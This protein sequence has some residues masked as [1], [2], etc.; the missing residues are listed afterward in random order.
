MRWKGAVLALVALACLATGPGPWGGR[1]AAKAPEEVTFLH[2]WTGALRGGIDAMLAEVARLE[3]SVHVRL[4]DFE[5]ETFKVGIK[6]MLTSGRPPDLFSYWAGART[7]ALA[8]RGQLANLDEI[9]KTHAL[10]RRFPPAVVEAC[11]YEGRMRAVPVTWHAVGF[12][13]DKKRFDSLGLRPPGTWE[14]F[15]AVCERLKASGV[16][17]LALGARERWP[18]QFWFDML[19]LRTAPDLQ[20]ALARGAH[21]EGGASFRDD[22]VRRVF[23]LWQELV[24]KGFF[25]ADP[26]IFDWAEAAQAMRHGKAGMTLMGSWAI[27]LLEGSLGWK[28]GEDYGFFPFPE[29]DPGVPLVGCGPM[30]LLVMSAVAEGAFGEA[31]GEARGAACRKALVAFADPAAQRAMSRGSGALAPMMDM[32][33]EDYSPVQREVLASMQACRRWAFAFDLTFPDAV[34]QK[35]LDGFQRFLAGRQDVETLLRDLD[36]AGLEAAVQP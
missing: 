5:H 36:D 13:Y 20:A 29:V 3:P 35:G 10:D 23:A 31:R 14:A 12:F 27:G 26:L 4:V 22:R 30:D 25:H 8:A 19:L 15:H 11:R 1:A 33:L 2:Y 9:W 32:P 21:G 17:P 18:A 7:Q 16:A 24:D 34:A 6:A 28:G